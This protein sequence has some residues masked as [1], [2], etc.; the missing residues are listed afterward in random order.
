MLPKP[1]FGLLLGEP[2]VHPAISAGKLPD[3]SSQGRLGSA[4]GIIHIPIFHVS[5]SV[6]SKAGTVTTEQILVD[7]GASYQVG[8]LL[9]L[10]F[11]TWF[12]SVRFCCNRAAT[13]ANDGT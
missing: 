1:V 8:R 11:E 2:D 4:E 9:G 12:N 6:F 13:V 10:E 7:D 5:H 3:R